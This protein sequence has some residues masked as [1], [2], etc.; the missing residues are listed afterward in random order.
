MLSV[1]LT[2]DSISSLGVL[3][4]EE[5]L[6]SVGSGAP[7]SVLAE[8]ASGGGI[9]DGSVGTTDDD[10]I[11]EGSVGVLDPPSFDGTT[12]ELSGDGD[13]VG[14]SAV[15]GALLTTFVEAFCAS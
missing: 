2:G 11:S 5:A 14:P 8:V 4:E 13:A 3:A 12:E 7:D 10:G 6:G 1:V 15:S 9:I